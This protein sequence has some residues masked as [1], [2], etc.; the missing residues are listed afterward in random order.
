MT[1]DRKNSSRHVYSFPSQVLSWRFVLV[2]ARERHPCSP[3]KTQAPPV[4]VKY[5]S[6]PPNRFLPFLP[7]FP[8]AA[9]Y[10]KGGKRVHRA[11]LLLPTPGGG[12]FPHFFSFRRRRCPG[13][14]G[15]DGQGKL[16]DCHVEGD[17]EA[18]EKNSASRE[19]GGEGGFFEAPGHPCRGKKESSSLSLLSLPVQIPF[20]L[21]KNLLEA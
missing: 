19:R 2:F 4:D 9:A 5:I 11:L 21:Q 13:G 3:P 10:P 12:F 18:G 17:G 16:D 14:K 8:E 6:N 15:G 1:E 20:L 7:H